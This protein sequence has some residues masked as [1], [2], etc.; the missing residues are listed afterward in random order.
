[1][2]T[3]GLRVFC[4]SQGADP[5]SQDAAGNSVVMGAAFKGYLDI[6]RMLVEAG[7]DVTHVNPKGQNAQDYAEMFGRHDAAAYHAGRLVT[8]ADSSPH[9]LFKTIRAEIYL[10]HADHDEHMPPEMIDR[11]QKALDQ[12]KTKH[13]AEIYKEAR[14]G[15]TMSDLPAYNA[16]GEHRH[17]VTLFDLLERNL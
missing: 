15:F 8:D 17:W 14:H 12:T 7:A 16:E 10:A 1:M 11:V 6:V 5:D 4:L 9:H 3:R 13:K 2:G